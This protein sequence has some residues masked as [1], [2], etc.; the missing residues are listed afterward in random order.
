MPAGKSLGYRRRF[1]RGSLHNRLPDRSRV[2]TVITGRICGPSERSI[3]FPW[4]PTADTAGLVSRHF[5][6]PWARTWVAC[7]VRFPYYD[8]RKRIASCISARASLSSAGFRRMP[9]GGLLG[10]EPLL[11]W[12]T[13][14]PNSGSLVKLVGPASIILDQSARIDWLP[15]GRKRAP[16]QDQAKK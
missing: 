9:W 3:L 14:D 6:A 11:V 8:F 2:R 1:A 10:Q 13:R 5:R 16:R 12:S 15:W 4:R 7:E